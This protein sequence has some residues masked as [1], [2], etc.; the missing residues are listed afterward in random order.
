MVLW[1]LIQPIRG[2]IQQSNR[3]QRG[4]VASVPEPGEEGLV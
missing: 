1:W 4:L 2:V 3:Q